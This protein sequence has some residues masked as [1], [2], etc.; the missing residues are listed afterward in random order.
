[1]ADL[2]EK[3]SAS[4]ATISTANAKA[5]LVPTEPQVAVPAD[6]AGGDV[7]CGVHAEGKARRRPSDGGPKL[8]QR[9]SATNHYG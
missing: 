6:A 1:M 4:A 2:V 5:T 8:K 7:L 9:N 3:E